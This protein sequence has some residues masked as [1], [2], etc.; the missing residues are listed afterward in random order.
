MSNSYKNT[1]LKM[2]KK[3]ASLWVF[4]EKLYLWLVCSAALSTCLKRKDKRES[5]W[6]IRKMCILEHVGNIRGK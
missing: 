3:R 6:A 2:K 4:D 1:K 5:Q